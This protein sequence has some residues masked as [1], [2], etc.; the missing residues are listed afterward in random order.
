MREKRSR[1][2]RTAE[3]LTFVMFALTFLGLILEVAVLTAVG[4]VA[5]IVGLLWVGSLDVRHR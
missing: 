2:Q 4:L 5:F 1:Q 3:W